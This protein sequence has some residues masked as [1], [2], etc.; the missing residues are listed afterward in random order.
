MAIS[1]KI[2]QLRVPDIVNIKTANSAILDCDY[3][4]DSSDGLVVKWFFGDSPF[5]VYQWIPQA[6]RPP[7]ALGILR[8]RLDLNYKASKNPNSMYRALNIKNLALNLTGEYRCVVSTF[9]KEDS[10]AKKMIVLGKF[11]SSLRL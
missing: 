11:L 1:Q 3:D 5:P 9:D 7:Q 2:K 6:G 8:D 10:Q 4:L